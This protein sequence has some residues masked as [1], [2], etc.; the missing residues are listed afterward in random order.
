SAFLGYNPVK[1]LIGPHVLAQTTPANRA[2]LEGHSF[3]AHLIAGSFHS[4]LQEA[5][6][7]ATAVCLLAAATSWW[8]GAEVSP[9]R[10]ASL[11]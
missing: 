3:F 1:T 5:F 10:V 7:F 9:K 8:R 11:A 2:A 4:G 6:I